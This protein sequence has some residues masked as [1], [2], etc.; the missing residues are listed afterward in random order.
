MPNGYIF[1]DEGWWNDTSW[2]DPIPEPPDNTYV[3]INGQTIFIPGP[4][5]R[6]DL[7]A[8]DG[9]VLPKKSL[10]EKLA[11]LL[12]ATP[13]TA[14]TAALFVMAAIL[15]IFALRRYGSL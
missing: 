6:K 1:Q 5:E 9:L 12:L 11:N 8:V 13:A 7:E 14:I 10:P 15:I 3:D 4:N 2:M